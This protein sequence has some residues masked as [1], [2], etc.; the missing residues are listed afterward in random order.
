MKPTTSSR[1]RLIADA[2]RIQNATK[3][4]NKQTNKQTKKKQKK[5]AQWSVRSSRFSSGER[6]EKRFFFS[7]FF[8]LLLLL[9]L[10]FFFTKEINRKLEMQKKRRFRRGRHQRT[11]KVEIEFFPF[12]VAFFFTKFGRRYHFGDKK[13]PKKC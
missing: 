11:S 5:N 7:S 6:N 9:L 1:R 4:T 13:K 12:F 8:L 3:Q 10:P 2:T